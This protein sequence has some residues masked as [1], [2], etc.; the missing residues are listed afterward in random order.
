M[1]PIIL[2]SSPSSFSSTL[3]YFP[4]TCSFWYAFHATYTFIF[5]MIII[6]HLSLNINLFSRFPHLLF[7]YHLNIL[8]FPLQEKPASVRPFFTFFIKLRIFK[9]CLLPSFIR[10]SAVY[11]FTVSYFLPT[12]GLKNFG[13]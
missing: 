3:I 11:V 13:K 10:L 4:N 1:S 2:I 7:F 12:L 8:Q 6:P 9:W 5:G